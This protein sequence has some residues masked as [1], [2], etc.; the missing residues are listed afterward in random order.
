MRSRVCQ[1]HRLHRVCQSGNTDEALEVVCQYIQALFRR[2]I[3]KPAHLEVSRAHP[4]FK[5]AEH[6]FDR[7]ESNRH[8]VKLTIQ[9]VLHRIE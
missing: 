5:R 6:M 7:S 3:P 9:S 1:I 8:G 2:N 4:M